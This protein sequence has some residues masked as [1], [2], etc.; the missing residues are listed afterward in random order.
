MLYFQFK[1]QYHSFILQKSIRWSFLIH[2]I[3]LVIL[4]FIRGSNNCRLFFEINGTY[5][6]DLN[7]FFTQQT[8]LVEIIQDDVPSNRKSEDKKNIAKNKS[9]VQVVESKKQNQKKISGIKKESVQSRSQKAIFSEKKVTKPPLK[10][11]KKEKEKIAIQKNVEKNKNVHQNEHINKISKQKNQ[12]DMITKKIDIDKENIARKEYMDTE[13]KR[14]WQPPV[15]IVS[16]TEAT[17]AVTVAADG[18]IQKID[19]TQS[20]GILLFDIT[21]QKA[22][23][24]ILFPLWARSMTIIITLKA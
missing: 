10:G 8:S 15:S 16:G 12:K 11:L 13:I 21:G 18:S 4:F 24:Q 9:V 14:V 3:V 19:V 1:N 2:I 5:N 23:Y 20:S 6:K 22:L 7:L 17:F